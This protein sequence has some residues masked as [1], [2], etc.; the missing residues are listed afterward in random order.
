MS[1][2][3]LLPLFVGFYLIYLYTYAVLDFPQGI[4]DFFLSISDKYEPHKGSDILIM[5]IVLLFFINRFFENRR[6]S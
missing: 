3:K 6:Y 4:M 5:T 2:S 1:V